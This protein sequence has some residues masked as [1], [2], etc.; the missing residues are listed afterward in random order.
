[1]NTSHLNDWEAY[2]KAV[3]AEVCLIYEELLHS[4]VLQANS[5]GAVILN[6]AR[7]AV[8]WD[9][10]VWPES[11]QLLHRTERK[12]RNLLKDAALRSRRLSDFTMG[13]ADRDF[14]ED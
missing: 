10:A 8:G 14:E 3:L 11:V 2:S 6:E 1:M 9:P 12:L 5:H 7:V 13:L 4:D